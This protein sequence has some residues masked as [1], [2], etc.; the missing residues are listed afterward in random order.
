MR[1]YSDAPYDADHLSFPMNARPRIHGSHIDGPLLVFSDGQI[2][3]LTLRER[4]VLWLGLTNAEKLQE[5]HRPVLCGQLAALRA[6][7][8]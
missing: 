8:A 2:H 5:E 4:I 1:T 6:G 7:A 3:W